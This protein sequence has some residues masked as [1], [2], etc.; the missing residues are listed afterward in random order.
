VA[1]SD[2]TSRIAASVSRSAG[3]PGASATL[4]ALP[5]SALGSLLL[6]VFRTRAERIAPADVHAAASRALHAP[7]A[8][9]ARTLHALDAAALEAASGFEAIDLAPVAP[10]G[11]CAALSA[12]DQNNV[13][14]TL[15]GAELL[16]DPTVALA[17]VAAARRRR[18]PRPREPVRLCASARL[19][20][21]QPI[22]TPVFTPH[23]RLFALVTAGRD[24]G[25]HRFET[26]AL[27]EHVLAW[28]ALFSRLRSEGFRIDGAEVQV[29]D[30]VAVEAIC[31]AAGVDV[32]EVRATAAAHR[33]GTAAEALARRGVTLPGPL[34]DPRRDLGALH[35]RIPLEAALRLDRV[36]E[37]VFPPIAVA[38]PEVPLRL[39]LSRLEGL[40]YYPSLMLRI[41]L[42][43]PPGALPVIDGGFTAW[44]QALLSDRKERLLASAFGSELVAK[45][46]GP[47]RQSSSVTSS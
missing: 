13:L 36:V 17:L 18:A 45:L 19:V 12:I 1:R 40:G 21:L 23:F 7:S 14:T 9:D 39:D 46:Y 27:R 34:R 20:R 38:Y 16:A 3:M 28:L 11:A 42:R 25:E 33:V 43:G 35:A 4:S 37:A 15:R 32:A 24:A 6:D 8:V 5:G 22:E 10:F 2:R 29:S 31:A 41:L 26:E 30:A 44:T 47:H